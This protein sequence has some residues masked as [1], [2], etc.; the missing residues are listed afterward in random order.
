MLVHKPN[1]TC[2]NQRQKPNSQKNGTQ[3][4]GKR[5]ED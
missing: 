2:M 5:I 4:N 1:G 3:T